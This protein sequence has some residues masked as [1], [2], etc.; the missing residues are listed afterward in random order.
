MAMKLAI[1]VAVKMIDSQR[2]IC[3]IQML[4]FNG[5]ST[6][7]ESF[8]HSGEWRTLSIMAARLDSDE[9]MPAS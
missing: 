1:T 5:T 6:V 8:S 9:A 3:R 4:Q 7:D 2:W